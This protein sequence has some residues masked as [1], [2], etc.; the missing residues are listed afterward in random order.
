MRRQLTRAGIPAGQA[1][2]AAQAVL[3]T[4]QSTLDDERGRW[5]LG[6]ARARREWPLIDAAGR[7]SVIDL[8]LSTEDGWLIVDYKTGR[9]HEHETPEQFA[10]RMRQRHGEQLMR[11][12]AQV[13]ALD[14]RPARAALYFPRARAWI[15]L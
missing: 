7:V 4:L 10:I 1:D 8:A 3:D 13:T 9:P 5:L 2:A 12:C 6:Q 15:D 14:G 11:Y